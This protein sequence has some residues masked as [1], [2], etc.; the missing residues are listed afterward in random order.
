MWGKVLGIARVPGRTPM[1]IRSIALA[2]LSTTVVACAAN[3][4]T[5]STGPTDPTGAGADNG[6]GAG[7]VNGEGGEGIDESAPH[8]LGSIVLGESHSLE[9]GVSNPFVGASF[10]PDAAAN[11]RCTKKVGVCEMAETPKCTTGGMQGC[12]SGES[13]VF[14]D[15]CVAKCVKQCTKSCTGGQSCVFSATA[16]DESG[17]ECRKVPRFE[18]GALVFDGTTT[19]LTMFPPYTSRVEGAGAPFMPKGE[20]RVMASGAKEAGFAA[21]D[22][23]FR[24]T[25]LLESNP[26]LFGTSRKALFGKG[27]V[28][29]SW[30][31]GEDKVTVVVSSLGGTVS[32]P[33]DD[34][35]G[36]FA[37]PRAAIQA[38]LGSNSSSPSSSNLSISITRERTELRAGK[39][40]MGE[41]P[42]ETVQPEGRV[43]LITSSTE[44]ASFSA[45][46]TSD[47]SCE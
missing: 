3:G 22:E 15:D 31:P 47:T 40:T 25:T 41:I 12:G 11:K 45:C 33:A 27:D 10:M 39:K 46:S 28:A 16:A 9:S 38:A 43:K 4:G 2:L 21:F 17:M 37:I 7:Q 29:V 14:N 18:A 36:T 24:A 13:C 42:G 5:T 26:P 35:S 20:L 8:A 19:S 23:K 44:V 6:N 30:V 32:C 1:Q 34:K